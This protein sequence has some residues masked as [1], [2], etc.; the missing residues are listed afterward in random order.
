M[1]DLT[2]DFERAPTINEKKCCKRRA[3]IGTGAEK[4]FRL[5][6]TNRARVCA[7]IVGLLFFVAATE[8]VPA[9]RPAPRPSNTAQASADRAG[10]SPTARTSLDAALA[11]LQSNDLAAAERAARAAVAA[12]P[13]SAI[14]HNVLGVVLDRARRSEEAFAEFN[15]AIKLDP[16]FVSARNNLGRMFAEHGKTAEAIAEF[17]RVLKSDPSHVQAH[18]NLGAL[19]AD[20]GDFAK[21]AEH[22]ARAREA[23]P[24]D[25]QLALAFLTVAYRANRTQ[26]A[27]AAADLVERTAGA[28]GK[29]TLYPGNGAG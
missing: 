28:D 13:R 14:T 15:A 24:N 25:P 12:S 1:S 6:V 3:A 29:S 22:F 17:E 10:L 9:Q 5:R 21:A 16:N 2:P 20:A 18:Y 26:Q 19:Y 7:Q 27:D 11:A 4:K 23:D 8:P